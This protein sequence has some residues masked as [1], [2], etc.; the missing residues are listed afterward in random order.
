MAAHE[1]A[2]GEGSWFSAGIYGT[3]SLGGFIAAA[4]VPVLGWLLVLTAIVFFVLALHQAW[5]T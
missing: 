4:A 1:K 5:T 2:A 3:I